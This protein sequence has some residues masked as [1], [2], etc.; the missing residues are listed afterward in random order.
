MSVDIAP[1]SLEQLDTTGSIAR[2]VLDTRYHD[3]PSDV[4]HATKRIILD[5]VA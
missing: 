2:F 4:V 5:T 3:L 1:P